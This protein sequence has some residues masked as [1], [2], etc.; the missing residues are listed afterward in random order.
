MEIDDVVV[1]QVEVVEDYAEDHDRDGINLSQSEGDDC[2][3]CIFVFYLSYVL[4]EL[5]LEQ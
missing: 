4:I 3:P 1:G 5:G 2:V